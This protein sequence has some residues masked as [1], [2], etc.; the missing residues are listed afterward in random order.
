MTWSSPPNRSSRWASWS[1][2][3]RPGCPRRGRP[4]TRYTAAARSCARPAQGRAGVRGDHPLRLS[5]S[6]LPSGAV[7]RADEAAQDAVFE[8]RSCGTGTKG[9]RFSDWALIATAV[10]RPVPADPPPDLP[11][12]PADLLPVLGAGRQP[13]DHDVLHHHRR[14]PLAGGGNVQNREGR[15]RLG[16]GPGPDLGRHLPAH[17]PGRPR[18][19]PPGRHPQRP[20]T[21]DITLPATPGTGVP[22][23]AAAPPATST[24][25]TLTCA[26]RSG[27]RPSPPAA[28]SPARP[29][30]PPSGCRSPRPPGSPAWPGRPPPGCITRA[31]LAFALRW[32]APAA[33]P[34]GHRPLAPPQRPAPRRSHLTPSDRKEVTACNRQP[35]STTSR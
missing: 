4:S 10:P 23:T 5:R 34:P 30:S 2:W 19:A 12:G 22:A 8:R 9:P 7:I 24:S 26:S 11:P 33:A 29:A 28:A 15:A 3:P 20:V 14:A 17:R 16:P 21:G 6:P 27:T 1:G 18:P 31:R 32:S 25:A 13:G 35:A